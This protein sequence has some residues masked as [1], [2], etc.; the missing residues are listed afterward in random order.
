[1]VVTKVTLHSELEYRGGVVATDRGLLGI[2]ADAHTNVSATPPTP[3][4]VGQ[5]KSKAVKIKNLLK[6]SQILVNF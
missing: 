1:M 6:N 5:L 2:V 4:V 3:D